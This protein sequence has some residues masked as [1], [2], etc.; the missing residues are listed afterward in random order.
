M[1]TGDT[2]NNKYRDGDECTYIHLTNLTACSRLYT[3]GF[4]DR[5]SAD[6]RGGGLGGWGGGSWG[7][8]WV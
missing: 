7:A 8:Q 4:T 6:G 1:K 3:C 5:K 2:S